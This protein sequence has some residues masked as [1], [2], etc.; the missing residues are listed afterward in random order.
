MTKKELIE[1]C[2]REHD[3]GIGSVK[4]NLRGEKVFDYNKGYGDAFGLLLTFAKELDE[5]AAKLRGREARKARKQAK[6]K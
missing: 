6:R 2:E 1:I 3:R 5:P 4:V